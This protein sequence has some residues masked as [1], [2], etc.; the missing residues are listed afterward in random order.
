[1]PVSDMSMRSIVR[2]TMGDDSPNMGTPPEKM[3]VWSP[4]GKREVHL[5]FNA[6][7]LL[8]HCGYTDF[9][10]AMRGKRSVD[11][12]P[13]SVDED[14]DT[15]IGLDSEELAA[16]RKSLTEAGVKVDARWGKK[17]LMEE[18]EKASRIDPVEDEQDAA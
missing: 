2:N 17:R 13:N 10:P 12:D 6:R 14:V 16:L 5:T 4:D 7:D 18:I 15:A 9:D 1:M 11:A 3:V 8:N